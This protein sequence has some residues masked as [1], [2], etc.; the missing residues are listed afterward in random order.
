MAARGDMVLKQHDVNAAIFTRDALA[1]VDS[2]LNSFRIAFSL[3]LSKYDVQAVYERLFT[4]VVQRVNEAVTVESHSRYSKTTVIGV[5]DIYGFEIFGT[6][7][8]TKEKKQA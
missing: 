2:N 3:Y 7:R 6:N 8:Y 1:K 5:L 4:W